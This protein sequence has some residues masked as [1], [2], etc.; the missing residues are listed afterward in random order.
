MTSLSKKRAVAERKLRFSSA[1]YRTM[2]AAGV[3]GDKRIELLEGT[4][5]VMPPQYS[6]H[7]ASVVM[8][9]NE[10]TRCFGPGYWV[11]MQGSVEISDHSM[12]DPDLAVVEGDM[13][14]PAYDYPVASQIILIGEVADSTLYRD[15]N[16]KLRIYAAAQI[17][18]YW[19]VNV[20]DRVLEVYREPIQISTSNG[21][22]RGDYSVKLVFLP[23]QVVTPLA[24]PGDAVSVT[25]LFT[26]S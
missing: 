25:N 21:K 26:K 13:S 24:R 15:R 8:T 19:I 9:C 3:F 12:P 5:F 22:S 18:E 2:A 4:I 1:S 10:L 16:R 11:R 20:R 6:Q 17:P 7:M 23:G 14:Q